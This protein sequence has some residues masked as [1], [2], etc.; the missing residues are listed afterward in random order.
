L[1]IRSSCPC[2]D[3]LERVDQPVDLIGGVV[4]GQADP[5]RASASRQPKPLDQPGRVEVTVPGGDAVPTER[6]GRLTRQLLEVAGVHLRRSITDRFSR[7]APFDGSAAEGR[8]E[9]WWMFDRNADRFEI[10][11]CLV[12]RFSDGP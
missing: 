11:N 4:V 1:K 8:P 6:F 12:R 5:E 9:S 2:H 3:P 10:G 7:Q